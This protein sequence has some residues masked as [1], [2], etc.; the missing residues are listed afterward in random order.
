MVRP[1]QSTELHKFGSHSKVVESEEKHMCK[2]YSYTSKSFRGTYRLTR[3]KQVKVDEMDGGRVD[4]YL[5]SGLQP[6]GRVKAQGQ[7]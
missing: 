2:G 6:V 3:V 1:V 5:H 4:T 7:G